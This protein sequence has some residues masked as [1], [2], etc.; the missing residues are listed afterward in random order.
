MTS[1]QILIWLVPIIILIHNLEEAVLMP[2]FLDKRNAAFP[3][4]LRGLLPP[5]NY[6]QFL[7]ASLIMTGIPFF[8]AWLANREGEN[9]GVGMFLLLSVQFMMLVNVFVHLGMAILMDGGGYAPGVVTAVVINL[10]F[11]VYLLWRAINEQWLAVK[12]IMMVFPLGL[13]LHAIALPL[14]II[15]SEKII[16]AL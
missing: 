7:L 5:I 16:K 4:F 8:I 13:L 2:A 15:F 9:S 3:N 10:P 6:G 12:M 11:S 14:T 1:K